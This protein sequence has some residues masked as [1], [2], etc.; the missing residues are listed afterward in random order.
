MF[1]C[2]NAIEEYMNIVKLP[3]VNN[4]HSVRLVDDTKAVDK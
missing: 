2:R 1:V 4:D 3:I